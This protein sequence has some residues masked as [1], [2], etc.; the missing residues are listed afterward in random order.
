MF[1]LREIAR[2]TQLKIR[3]L[4]EFFRADYS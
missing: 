4:H 3:L 2:I 1:G